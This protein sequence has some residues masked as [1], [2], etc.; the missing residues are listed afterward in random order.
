MSYI[1][2][3]KKGEMYLL[4]NTSLTTIDTAD[5]WHMLCLT[6]IAAGK[7]IGWTFEAGYCHN[8]I[9]A[10]ATS[11]AGTRTKVT[12]TAAHLLSA[13]DIISI[14]GTTNYND[15]YEVLESVDAN[16]FTIDKAWDGND[17]ATGTL[18]KG[19]CIIAGEN[20]TG[21]YDSTWNCTITPSVNNHIFTM[22][23]VINK[24]PCNKCR[25]R[26]KLGTSGDYQTM[27]GGA[28]TEITEGDKLAFIIKNVG[29]TGNCTLRHG[30]VKSHR[31]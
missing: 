13:E 15:I 18:S 31:A 23:F 6:E 8:D 19:A 28:F 25:A 22:G 26:Q 1:T 11:D 16:N 17:D 21:V 3:T 14:T 20:S 29:G 27:A 30:N 10:Y 12:T 4:S 5:A 2:S 24:T 7:L 9:T